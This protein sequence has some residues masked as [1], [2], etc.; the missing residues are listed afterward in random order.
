MQAF[1]IVKLFGCN[2][3]DLMNVLDKAAPEVEGVSE[4]RR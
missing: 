4:Q 3:A 1:F 2:A